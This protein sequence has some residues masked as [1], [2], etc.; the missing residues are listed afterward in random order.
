MMN[1]PDES[2]EMSD[3]I[4]NIDTG[5]EELIK[6]SSTE[7]LSLKLILHGNETSHQTVQEG[8]L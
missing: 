8:I 2:H 7:V 6:H 5:E 4:V 1:P 3:N